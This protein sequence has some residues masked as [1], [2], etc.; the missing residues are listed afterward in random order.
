MNEALVVEKGV[1]NETRILQGTPEISH[2]LASLLS[3]IS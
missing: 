1:M 2:L 3:K